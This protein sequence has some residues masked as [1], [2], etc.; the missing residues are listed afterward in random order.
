MGVRAA[1]TVAPRVERTDR[2]GTQYAT[3]IHGLRRT[4]VSGRICQL[5]GC[6]R[7]LTES[8]PGFLSATCS[9]GYFSI[10]NRPVAA[11][12]TRIALLLPI[13]HTIREI[14]LPHGL[15]QA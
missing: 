14:R 3:T 9:V 11:H 10:Y 15:V 8:L 7:R 2:G 4:S 12:R 6:L 13:P 5:F 1:L